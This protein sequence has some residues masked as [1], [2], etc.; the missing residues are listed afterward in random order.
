VF[1]EPALL[2]YVQTRLWTYV[3]SAGFRTCIGP[4]IMIGIVAEATI[5]CQGPLKLDINRVEPSKPPPAFHRSA[6]QDIRPLVEVS[7]LHLSPR[8]RR[9]DPRAGHAI[10]TACPGANAALGHA[11]QTHDGPGDRN[12]TLDAEVALRGTAAEVSVIVIDWSENRMPPW[13]I[14]KMDEPVDRAG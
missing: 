10:T 12:I 13:C 14:D 4:V 3:S 7:Q 11:T 2:T 5:R 8:I 6:E 1:G 9:P